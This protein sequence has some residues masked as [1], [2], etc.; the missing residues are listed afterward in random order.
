MNNYRKKSISRK[1]KNVVAG[2]G[3]IGKPISK[4]ISPATLTVEYDIN[5]KL[6]NKNKL[7][8]YEKYPTNFLQL[9]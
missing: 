3:E 8:Q 4:L 1:N 9:H 5:P 6:I 7:N 2:L